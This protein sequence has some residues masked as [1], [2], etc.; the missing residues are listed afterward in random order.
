[1]R[2]T[3]SRSGPAAALAIFF[4]NGSRRSPI[5]SQN[6]PNSI[7]SVVRGGE[8]VRE[9]DQLERHLRRLVGA[10]PEHEPQV[11]AVLV[12]AGGGERDVRLWVVDDARP[13]LAGRH[14]EDVR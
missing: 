5:C 9:A 6:G 14:V 10:E 12:D 8:R 1:M 3:S 7:G 2:T 4:W 13:K 11:V